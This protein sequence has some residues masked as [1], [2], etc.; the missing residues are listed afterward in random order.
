MFFK[1]FYLMTSPKTYNWLQQAWQM[2]ADVTLSFGKYL[3]RTNVPFH[4]SSFNLL[5]HFD[6]LSVAERNPSTDLL[7]LSFL[8]NQS[9]LCY[10]CCIEKGPWIEKDR[11][12]VPS[13]SFLIFSDPRNLVDIT[14]NATDSANI[15]KPLVLLNYSN[16]DSPI[17]A[18]KNQ[19][20]WAITIVSCI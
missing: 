6:R 15:W 9:T 2:L 17:T 7:K 12:I 8:Q 11:E 5:H 16:Q 20:R 4:L 1:E 19:Q 10:C 18:S 3:Y 14:P 13:E